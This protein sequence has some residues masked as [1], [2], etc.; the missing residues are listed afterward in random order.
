MHK[1]N[2]GEICHMTLVDD[3]NFRR[4]H[5]ICLQLLVSLLLLSPVAFMNAVKEEFDY[6]ACME[7]CDFLFQL[8]LQASCPETKLRVV[9][10]GCEDLRSE[11]VDKCNRHKKGS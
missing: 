6:E 11:C 2:Y 3:A 4:I 7:V 8:R 1:C 10:T 5:V 9:T